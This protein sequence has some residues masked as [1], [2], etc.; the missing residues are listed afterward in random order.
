M[1]LGGRIMHHRSHRFHIG[2]DL[3]HDARGVASYTTEPTDFIVWRVWRM[4][5][6]GSGIM[7]HGSHRFY[8]VNDMVHDANPPQK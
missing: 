2:E 8:I 3:V 5:R 4:R 6:G 7:Q 1:M